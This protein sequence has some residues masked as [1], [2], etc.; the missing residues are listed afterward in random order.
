MK[1]AVGIS[2]HSRQ[3]YQQN[4]ALLTGSGAHQSREMTPESNLKTQAQSRGPARL[5]SYTSP[6]A[7]LHHHDALRVLVAPLS[8][9]Y[10]AICTSVNA[11]QR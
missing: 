9:R 8:V 11:E 3:K 4:Y 10:L 7:K 5:L 2:R 1:P 6:L